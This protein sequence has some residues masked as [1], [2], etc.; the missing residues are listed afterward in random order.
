MRHEVF[1]TGG[2]AYIGSRLVPL[3]LSRG[4][5]VR[6]LARPGSETKLPAGCEIVSGDALRTET[7]A[8]RVAPA[9][10]F[11]QLVGVSHPSPAK[12]AQ[13]RDVNLASAKA[14]AE[15]AAR[16]GV[17]HFVYVSVARLA[18]VMKAYQQ[19]RAEAEA[20]IASKARNATFLRPW[21]VLGP[22][23]RWPYLF[24]PVYR[25]GEK[26][27]ATRESARRLGLVTIGQMLSALVLAIENPPRGI[28][29]LQVPDL[30]A[31]AV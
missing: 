10:T 8:E 30:R 11:V 9:D 4:H 29:I 5:R 13:F 3:L 7:F 20:F 21:Y 19:A 17:A 26:L 1:V 23:H 27:P 16:A 31:A 15:A 12:A 6:A 14:S 22:G 24:Y 28:R 25:V 2:T 18:P